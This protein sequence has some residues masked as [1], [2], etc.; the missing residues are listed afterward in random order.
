[1][2]DP[3]INPNLLQ[4]AINTLGL[5]INTMQSAQAAAILGK[6]DS[7]GFN[8]QRSGL[9]TQAPPTF[10]SSGFDHQGSGLGGQVTPTSSS[11]PFD[12]QGSAVES[13]DSD[14]SQ[15]NHSSNNQP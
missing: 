9:E 7:S 12:H 15:S 13:S 2:A 5:R 10:D 11:S 6:I 1:M 14:S 3:N 8:Y 4:E